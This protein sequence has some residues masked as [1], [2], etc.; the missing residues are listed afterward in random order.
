MKEW[1]LKKRKPA[2]LVSMIG[3]GIL[4]HA[5][6]AW[7]CSVCLSLT[8]RAREAYY[9]TTALLMLIPFLLLGGIFFWLRRAMKRQKEATDQPRS[10]HFD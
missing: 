8:D 5:P 6:A 3:L 1:L 4:A 7:A 9:G 10:E 2:L